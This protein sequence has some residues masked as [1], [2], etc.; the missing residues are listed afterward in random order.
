MKV[1]DKLKKIIIA[2]M[3]LVHWRLEINYFRKDK[4]CSVYMNQEKREIH[5]F[6]GTKNP[7]TSSLNVLPL[8]PISFIY[9]K[10]IKVIHYFKN[11][12]ITLNIF[13]QKAFQ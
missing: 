6:G 2:T 1:V 3:I 8:T 4:M 11:Y 12:T 7:L 9:Y 5:V 10:P 13:P